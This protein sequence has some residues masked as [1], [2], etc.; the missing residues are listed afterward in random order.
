MQAQHNGAILLKALIGNIAVQM[1]FILYSHVQCYKVLAEGAVA[2]FF[3]LLW[4]LRATLVSVIL[5]YFAMSK[6]SQDLSQE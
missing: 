3:I 4:S 6:S 2:A 1:I 5:L